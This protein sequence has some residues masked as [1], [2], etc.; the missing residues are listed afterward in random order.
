ALIAPSMMERLDAARM[1]VR[2]R[3]RISIAKGPAEAELI[4]GE[5]IRLRA[6]LLP[7]PEPVEPGGFDYAR[8]VWFERIGGVGF[9]FTAP[10]RIAPAPN[11]A[12]TALARLRHRITMRVQ[13]AIGGAAGPVAAALITGEQRAIPKW[14]AEDLRN[15]GLAHV[16]SISGLHMALFGGSLFW[17]VRACFAAVPAIALRF[18]I[19]KWGAAAALLGS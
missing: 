7:P 4:P 6:R 10:E 12:A 14:A 11:D 3:L 16:L 1:P 5:T 9:A 2:L 17:L 19:K 18:S 15:A 13:T 8:Q